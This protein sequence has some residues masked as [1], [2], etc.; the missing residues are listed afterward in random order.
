VA[1]AD[2]IW[3][4]KYAPISNFSLLSGIRGC[5]GGKDDAHP[6]AGLVIDR[7][8]NLYGTANQGGKHKRIMPTRQRWLRYGVQTDGRK[9]SLDFSPSL[10]LS[11]R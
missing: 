1:K 4:G 10:A 6:Y 7:N 2:P 9:I 5:P 8:G 3:R 11:R